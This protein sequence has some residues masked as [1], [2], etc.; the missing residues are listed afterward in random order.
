MSIPSAG[1]TAVP[2]LDVWSGR[3]RAV[4]EDFEQLM[5][6]DD[7]DL[8]TALSLLFRSIQTLN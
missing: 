7:A 4:F 1:A 6:K 3:A 8:C 5:M 2:V